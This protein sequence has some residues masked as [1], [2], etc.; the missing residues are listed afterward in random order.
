MEPSSPW[1]LGKT[2]AIPLCQTAALS[3]VFHKNLHNSI[4]ISI[5]K[6]LKILQCWSWW[7]TPV[8]LK[9]ETQRQEDQRFTVILNYTLSSRSVWAVRTL[10]LGRQKQSLLSPDGKST[11]DENN[12]TIKVQLG[13]TTSLLRLCRGY[14]VRGYLQK[15]SNSKAATSPKAQPGT[16]NDSWKLC[17]GDLDTT[18]R[19]FHQSKGFSAA[20][21]SYI[22]GEEEDPVHLVKPQGLP[23][24]CELFTSWV[25]RTSPRWKVST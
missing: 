18:Y 6:Q 14:G 21:T 17:P 7:K 24:I 25:L 22:L 13:E 8:I 1:M 3:I 15:L 20:Y 19:W 10:F 5:K 23:E 16:G 9:L 4:I 2:S 11:I 12:D